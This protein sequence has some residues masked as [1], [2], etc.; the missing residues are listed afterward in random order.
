MYRESNV[1]KAAVLKMK[2]VGIVVCVKVSDVVRFRSEGG[3]FG[4]CRFRF[5]PAD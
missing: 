1:S 2:E 3:M 5:N 4:A